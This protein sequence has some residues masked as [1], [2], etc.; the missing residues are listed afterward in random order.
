MVMAEQQP[1]PNQGAEQKQGGAELRRTPRR[2]FR[3]PVGLLIKGHYFLLHARQLSEGGVLVRIGAPERTRRY[4]GIN[5]F[6]YDEEMAL[7]LDDFPETTPVLVTLTLPSGFT[8]IA[9]GKVIYHEKELSEDAPQYGAGIG[10]RFDQDS[11][12]LNH[13]RQIRNYV[14]SKLASEANDAA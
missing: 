8:L 11:M 4:T 6:E 3:R 7:T 14:S 12:P 13:R 9:P 2:P 5:Q 1:S 10:I